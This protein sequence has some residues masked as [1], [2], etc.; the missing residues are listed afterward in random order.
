MSQS[1]VF[2]CFGDD[3]RLYVPFGDSLN[4]GA[5]LDDNR[6][7]KSYHLS[8]GVSHFPFLF[9]DILHL[10]LRVINLPPEEVVLTF[11][12]QSKL[13]ELRFPID[14]QINEVGLGLL[15]HVFLGNTDGS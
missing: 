2:R 8:Q 15:F 6:T 10:R 3:C 4:E 9:L 7:V 14:T 11:V 1:S 13:K 12:V 5:W